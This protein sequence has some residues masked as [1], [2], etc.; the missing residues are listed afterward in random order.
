VI[1]SHKYRFIFIKTRKTAGS[2]LEIALSQFL[3][4]KDVITPCMPLEE[5]I[6]RKQLGYRPAQNYQLPLRR[7]RPRHYLD[8]FLGHRPKL[9]SAHSNAQRIFAEIPLDTWNGYTKILTVR[10][11]YSYVLSLYLWH[12][13]HSKATVGGFR[14][15]LL[16]G[17]GDLRFTNYGMGKVEGKSEVDLVL[18]FED[19]P[20]G[21][22]SLCAATGV[23]AGLMEGFEKIH[24][25]QSPNVS[26]LSASDAYGGFEAGIRYV[27][28]R[29]SEEISLFGYEKP[30]W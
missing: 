18:K 25:K 23:P 4:E 7:W 28:N 9:F 15:W 11:P 12:S 13:R 6:V 10:N 24:A 14:E 22:R 2:S 26:R 27:E 5:E 17:E 3:G 19:L 30:Q 8:Y 16:Q 20:A 1:I 21:I 29:F